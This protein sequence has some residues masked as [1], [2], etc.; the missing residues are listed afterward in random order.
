MMHSQL[1][2]THLTFHTQLEHLGPSIGLQLFQS[3]PMDEDINTNSQ[4]ALWQ[5][6]LVK[7]APL[8]GVNSKSVLV[9]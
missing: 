1:A 8:T 3:I 9:A 2:D 4:R 6:R 5:P 7:S